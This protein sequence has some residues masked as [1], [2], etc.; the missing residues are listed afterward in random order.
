MTK[1]KSEFSWF[2]FQVKIKINFS[3]LTQIDQN[4]SPARRVWRNE[5]VE[6]PTELNHRHLKPSF[7]C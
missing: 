6:R 7:R 1:N 3:T 5:N 4:K 2:Y